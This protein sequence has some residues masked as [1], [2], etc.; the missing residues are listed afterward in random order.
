MDY[1]LL[2]KY[3]IKAVLDGRNCL[4]K[5]K[6]KSMGILYRGIGRQ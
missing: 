1:S 5:K 2:S 6:I 4:D 3:N